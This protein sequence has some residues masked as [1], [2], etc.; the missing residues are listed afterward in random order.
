MNKVTFILTAVNESGVKRSKESQARCSSGLGIIS[1][2]CLQSQFPAAE[3]SR[4]GVSG[5][6]IDCFPRGHLGSGRA[7]AGCKRRG[8]NLDKISGCVGAGAGLGWVERQRGGSIRMGEPEEG[9]V[10]SN[11]ATML[12][13]TDSKRRQGRPCHGRFAMHLSEFSTDIISPSLCIN[14]HHP[15]PVPL[16]GF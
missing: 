10:R 3:T 13:C 9:R 6:Q 16:P 7:R 11:L 12:G 5:A 15:N 8:C 4:C 1:W 14:E 2:G